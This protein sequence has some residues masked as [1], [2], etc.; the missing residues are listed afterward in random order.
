MHFMGLLNLNKRNNIEILCGLVSRVTSDQALEQNIFNG[1][2]GLE[3][4]CL[5][6][7]VTP[8]QSV[9]QSMDRNN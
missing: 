1:L 3:M 4:E 6:W 9:A 8:A 2:P 7:R 5:K